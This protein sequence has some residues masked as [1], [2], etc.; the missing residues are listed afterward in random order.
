MYRLLIYS[1]IILMQIN[2]GRIATAQIILPA[3]PKLDASSYLVID[4]HSGNAI[5]EH[6]ID[7]RL[8][9]ASLTK[10][11]TVY[12]IAHELKNGKIHLDDLVTISEKA[13]RTPGS[14]MF[15]EV[16]KEVSVEELLKGVIIQSG[17]DASVALAE[18][19]SGDEETFV[20]VMNWHAQKLG[21]NDTHYVNSTGLPEPDHYTT[22]RDLATLASWLI[23]DFP[24]IY[25]WHAIREFTYNGIKQYNRNKLLWRKHSVDGIKTGHTESAGYC[26]VVSAVENNMRLISVVMGTNSSNARAKA[27]QSLLNYAFRFYETHKLYDQGESINMA[28]VWKGAEENIALG[29]ERELYITIP[30]GQYKKLE[31]T[32]N[33]EKSIV[34]P[35]DK[36][37]EIGMLNIQLAGD[38]ILSRPIVALHSVEQGGMFKRFKDQVYLLFE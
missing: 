38:K 21:L 1:I 31:A 20:N 34:A 15:I 10:I 28:K 11:M 27:S 33:I 30:R 12:A 19:A 17:N 3:P 14:K 22:A 26:L 2:F 37:D 7:K 32:V 29:M 8:P 16:N 36:G 25:A 4:H 9:S 6:D 23:N 18:F 35:I 24:E 5:V 13:W